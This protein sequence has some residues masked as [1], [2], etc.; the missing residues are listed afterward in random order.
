LHG[1]DASFHWL[2]VGLRR[3]DAGLRNCAI[4]INRYGNTLAGCHWVLVGNPQTLRRMKVF[5]YGTLK[6]GLRNA[7]WN[8]AR[9]LGRYRTRER[10]P[11]LVLGA[12]CL[13]W[14]SE[15][16]GRGELVIGELYQ[17]TPD[18]LAHMDVL[19]ELDKPDWYR[20]GEIALEPE[21]GGEPLTAFVYFGSPLR[22]ARETV[23]AGP[24]TE[25]SLDLEQRLLSTRR[26]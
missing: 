25:Y 13:P 6:Q 21:G 1:S 2:Q 15:E 18:Q 20:R 19:E 22:A 26:Y 23:Q 14:L 7:H 3:S 12:A 5:V 8:Q 17:A 24:L 9:L 10:F 11:L 16:P 4:V